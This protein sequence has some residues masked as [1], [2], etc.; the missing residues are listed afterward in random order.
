MRGSETRLE[1]KETRDY[2][3]YVQGTTEISV[4][5]AEELF[6]CLRPAILSRKTGNSVG[7]PVLVNSH[8]SDK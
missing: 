3:I 4:K 7:V 5:S 8:G 1:I 2:G 6:E